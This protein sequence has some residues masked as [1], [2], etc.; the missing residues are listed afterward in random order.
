MK[1][2]ILALA[3]AGLFVTT[4][5]AANVYNDDGTEVDVY[6]R[7]QFDI[8][9][10]GGDQDVEG[11]GSARLGFKAKSRINDSINALGRGEWQI[12]A[13]NE[14]S[15]KFTAR[16]VYA[17]FEFV[18]SGQL[19]FGQ[20]DTAFYQAV[21]ATDIFNTYG[22]AAFAGIE[23]G[24]Q[25]GQIVYDGEFGG[26]YVGASYQ[27]SNDEFE[28]EVG[29]PNNPTNVPVTGADLDAGYALTLG[30]NFDFGLG[31]Y[32]GY[33]VEQ[34]DIGDKTN[35]A[36][37]A[38]YSRNDLYLGGAYVMADLE[39]NELEG[40]DLVAEYS[41]NAL[42]VYGGY[43]YQKAGGNISGDTADEATF[44]V[45]YKLNSNMKTWIEYKL[46]N[47]GDQDDAVNLGLQYN[48]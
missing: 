28:I 42:A 34:L 20:T 13:E 33:H 46:D 3:V 36:L 41:F 32:G 24:R 26:F 22:Y 43:A 19:V 40:Y 7:F 6:G 31:V 21:A 12:A 8:R 11:L 18:D 45:A 15:S 2:S 14:D 9:D 44:A 29:N 4:A 17:G 35:T 39:G 47:M 10:S 37:S 23:D 5:Q 48:Y 25:P 1:K 16:H 30:Y 27:F 38:T